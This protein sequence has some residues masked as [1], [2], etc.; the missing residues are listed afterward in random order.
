MGTCLFSGGKAAEAWSRGYAKSRAIP[1]LSLWTFVTWREKFIV[2][3]DFFAA[4]KA[5]GA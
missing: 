4:R 3:E 5:A 2:I 1:L